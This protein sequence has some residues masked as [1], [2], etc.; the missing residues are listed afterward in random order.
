MDRQVKDY[1]PLVALDGGLDGLAAYR[2]LLPQ[3]ACHLKHEGISI[4]E[5]GSK[6]GKIL[7]KISQKFFRHVCVHQDLR[8][9]DRY[10]FLSHSLSIK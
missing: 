7:H 6:Q 2:S 10:L 5:I 4:L 8:G 9:Q 3:I 1:D